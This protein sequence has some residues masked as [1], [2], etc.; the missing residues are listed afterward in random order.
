MFA[1]RNNRQV[2]G[3]EINKDDY[4][5]KFKNVKE[6]LESRIQAINRIDSFIVNF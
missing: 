4:F 3:R 6:Y 2:I 1:V 5:G